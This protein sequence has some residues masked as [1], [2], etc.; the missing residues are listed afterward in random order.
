MRHA[1]L[2]HLLGATIAMA[3]LAGCGGAAPVPEAANQIV[4]ARSD[5]SQISRSATSSKLL[6]I[7]RYSSD[8]VRIYDSRTLALVGSLSGIA[9]PVGVALDSRRNVYVVDQGLNVVK[10][11]H[12][13]SGTPFETLTDPDGF[14]IQVT[15][16]NDGTVYVSNEY[17]THLGN[18]NVVVYPPGETRPNRRIDDSHFSVVED[19]GLDSHNNLYVTFFDFHAVGRVNEY[20]S[21]S[22]HGKTLPISLNGAGGIELDSNNDLVLADP[23]GGSVK[24]FAQGASVP[25]YEFAKQFSPWDV[26]LARNSTRAFVTDQFTGNTYEYALPSGKRLNVIPN[27][28]YYT[29]GVAV[30]Q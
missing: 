23:N 1:T 16:G 14:A 29:R 9:N 30:E 20:P 5:R 10:V 6:Y 13:G 12:R 3:L 24:V 19:V 27:P 8:D 25:K 28:P 4:S 21:G 17:N 15:V 18:G 11:F 2:F 22:T 26:A 7:A